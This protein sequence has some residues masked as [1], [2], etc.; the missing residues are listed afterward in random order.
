[1]LKWIKGMVL[2]RRLKA[3]TQILQREEDCRMAY[4][5]FPNLV[6]YSYSV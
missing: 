5:F 3:L 2:L 4:C 6:K 1:M